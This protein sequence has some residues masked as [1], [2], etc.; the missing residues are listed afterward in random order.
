MSAADKGWPPTRTRESADVP[1]LALI[2]PSEFRRTCIAASLSSYGF[3]EISGFKDATKFS[4]GAHHDLTIFF[5]ETGSSIDQDVEAEI[6][7]IR[8]CDSKSKIVIMVEK[9]TEFVRQRVDRL[10]QISSVLSANLEPEFLSALLHVIHR[11]YDVLPTVE[12]RLRYQISDELCEPHEP[13]LAKNH[14]SLAKTTPRQRQVLANLLAGC[15][16]KEIAR[17]LSISE[18]TVKTHVYYLMRN[19][20]ASNRTQVALKFAFDGA[21]QIESKAAEA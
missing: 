15:S 4:N 13:T 3:S 14:P 12:E 5:F 6:D 16:N 10:G 18:S 11:G 19:L 8:G 9:P 20:G 2:D 21:G 17:R 7:W 1:S